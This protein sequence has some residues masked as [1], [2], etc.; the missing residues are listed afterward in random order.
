[1]PMRCRCDGCGNV[2]NGGMGM[3]W[4]VASVGCVPAILSWYPL[5][6]HYVSI[7]PAVYFL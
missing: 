4:A 2:I 3:A 1:M 7:Q 6:M 5:E